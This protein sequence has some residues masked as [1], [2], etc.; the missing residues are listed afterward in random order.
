MTINPAPLACSTRRTPHGPIQPNTII[1]GGKHCHPDGG[2]PAHAVPP[3][4]ITPSWQAPL[5]TIFDPAPTTLSS[6]DWSIATRNFH[7]SGPARPEDLSTTTS[8]AMTDS[9]SAFN[10]SQMAYTATAEGTT[11]FS[12]SAFDHVQPGGNFVSNLSEGGGN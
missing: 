7:H 11:L 3:S 9:E 1:G 5:S 8:G 2:A 6:P 10:Q 12:D 4:T